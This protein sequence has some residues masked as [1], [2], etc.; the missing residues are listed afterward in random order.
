MPELL[1]GVVGDAHGI[2]CARKTSEDVNA[3]KDTRDLSDGR[4]D[5]VGISDVQLSEDDPLLSVREQLRQVADGEFTLL[6]VDVEQRDFASSV[7]EEPLCDG[8]AEAL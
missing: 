4:P 3:V 8:A 2:D 5:R 6:F 1:G 7:L